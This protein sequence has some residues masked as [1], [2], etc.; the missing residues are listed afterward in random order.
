MT[1]ATAIRF[2]CMSGFQIN[3]RDQCRASC[4]GCSLGGG[5]SGVAPTLPSI[6]KMAQVCLQ[7]LKP[8]ELVAE[9][10]CSYSGL[11]K[12]S[13]C[14]DMIHERSRTHLLNCILFCGIFDSQPS[15]NC[16]ILVAHRALSTGCVTFVHLGLSTTQHM[17]LSNLCNF[18]CPH[19]T[20]LMQVQAC[21]S[22]Q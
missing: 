15:A 14:G 7:S 20:G 4:K 5:L 8:S 17:M 10:L 12:P 1:A 3:S 19:V 18:L 13:A 21:I 9:V 16:L 11:Y 22:E 2:L 6:L